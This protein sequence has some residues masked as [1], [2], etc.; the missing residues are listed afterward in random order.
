[1]AKIISGFTKKMNL[2]IQILQCLSS[3][4]VTK[5]T[6]RPITVKYTEKTKQQQRDKL[7]KAA[8]KR[9]YVQRKTQQD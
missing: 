6:Y 9:T 5:S 8:K 1:M 4:T 2:H 3:K 7:L